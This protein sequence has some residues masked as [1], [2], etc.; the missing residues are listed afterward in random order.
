MIFYFI[1]RPINHLILLMASFIENNHSEIIE[2]DECNEYDKYDKY[3]DETECDTISRKSDDTEELGYMIID[4][5]KSL[6]KEHI[7]KFEELTKQTYEKYIHDLIQIFNDEFD[8]DISSILELLLPIYITCSIKLKH[9]NIDTN[10]GADVNND[11]E[12]NHKLDINTINSS[13]TDK[14][15]CLGI[16]S[17][18]NRCKALLTKVELYCGRHTA[19]SA[20]LHSESSRLHSESSIHSRTNSI[21]S[22][23]SQELSPQNIKTS[24]HII[25]ES[26]CH[27]MTQKQ[28]QCTRNKKYG[29]YCGHH[30]K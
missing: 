28:K 1:N 16:T 8:Q 29:N 17:T 9:T 21:V 27:A 22:K 14:H 25:D 18:G 15:Q 12:S 10:V 6:N 30:N 11:N 26:K 24:V 7:I 19:Q 2:Y 23:G 13:K 5:L 3:D 4:K 20:G